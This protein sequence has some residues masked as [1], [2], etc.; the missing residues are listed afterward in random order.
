MLGEK[1][2]IDKVLVISFFFISK[3]KRKKKFYL[4]D[5]GVRKI[6]VF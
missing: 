2:K 4:G 1:F 3:L 5:F 6:R